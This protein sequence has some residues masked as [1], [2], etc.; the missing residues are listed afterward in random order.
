M[1]R[2]VIEYPARFQFLNDWSTVSAYVLGLSLLLFL[3]NTVY[4]LLIARTP[5]E[6]NPWYSRSLEWQTASPP[7]AINFEGRPLIG[8]LYDYGV[9][10]LGERA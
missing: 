1:P 2:R 10:P 7:P 3:V 5:A 9:P 6:E 4:S 8:T